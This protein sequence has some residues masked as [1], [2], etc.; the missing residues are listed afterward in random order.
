MEKKLHVVRH[1]A[2]L[3]KRLSCP[4]CCVA[5]QHYRM[6]LPRQA[7]L[8][9]S[10]GGAEAIYIDAHDTWV[11][12]R[13]QLRACHTHV[14]ASATQLPSCCQMYL[15]AVVMVR[16]SGFATVRCR[17]VTTRCAHLWLMSALKGSSQCVAKLT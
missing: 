3:L 9:I 16:C 17:L 4:P 1:T 11:A 5:G 14:Y 8:C 13:L 15:P 7:S 6:R 10:I 2:T 12:L